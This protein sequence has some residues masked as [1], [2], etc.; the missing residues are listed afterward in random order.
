ME[1]QRRLLIFGVLTMA[2]W[3]GW[4]AIGPKFFPNLFPKP[5]EQNVAG[6][7]D[8]TDTPKPVS[9]DTPELKAAEKVADQPVPGHGGD[10]PVLALPEF[11]TQ[12]LTLGSM[13][14]QSAYGLSV[15]LTSVGAAIRSATLNDPRYPV[16]EN[17]QKLKPVPQLRLLGN[18]FSST[19]QIQPLDPERPD[20]T[21]D[22]DFAPV[23]SV[24]RQIN[25]TASLRTI[26][27]ELTG[28]ATD[29]DG[30]VSGCTF[31]IKSPDGKFELR[32]KFQLNRIPAERLQEK[33]VR[34][35]EP[36]AYQLD[37]ALQIRNTSSSEQVAEYVLQ[38]PAGLPLEYPETTR[39]YRDIKA[40]F[41]TDRGG[42][43]P[44]TMTAIEIVKA[45]DAQDIEEWTRPL[46]Y[47]GVD[48]Q[49][50]AAFVQPVENQLQTP[51]FRATR[52]VLMTR[53]EP[54]QESDISVEL[55]SSELTIPSDGGV[56]HR[57]KLFIGPKRMELL[58]PYQADK[59]LEYGWFA[60][61]SPAMVWLVSMFHDW[62]APYWIAIIMLTVIV[63]AGM[64]PISKR[65]AASG[66]KMKDLQ[67]QIMELREKYK[68]D[69][70]KLGQAQME[71]YSKAGVNPLAGCLPALIQ[72][73]IFISLYQALSNW[74]DLRMAPFLW[75]GDLSAPDALFR[76]PFRIPYLGWDFNLL[77][78]VTLVLF[79]MQQKLV[80][81]P[82]MNEEMAM[83]QKMM[84]YMT[85]FFGFLFYH[86]P[87]GLCVYFIASSCWSITE[88]QILE[89]LPEPKVDPAVVNKPR[90]EGFLAR[91]FKQ[92]QEAA[93]LQQQ[94]QKQRDEDEKHRR[95]R[96]S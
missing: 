69:K 43:A 74:V 88:R 51:Q 17:P 18:H 91:L 60:F 66:K 96:D 81:P 1:H 76:F 15:E 26:N 41:L 95:R 25:R 8:Q 64:F 14:P 62:G 90:K 13:D 35:I 40:G 92:L 7:P 31:A 46:L 93:E 78:I 38:G 39:K 32:K 71:L 28:K 83:Q 86:V 16:A 33:A 57:L 27:W 56:E 42:L 50:F 3:F 36:L 20:L 75:I 21:Y 77:P 4:L 2:T 29:A 49:Y 68:D 54:R 12:T 37:V 24:L 79:F 23:D 19:E 94:L 70:Q 58:E 6:N 52:P 59:L 61:L 22:I 63:R 11:S 87:A 5:P 85:L 45:H 82:P 9:P 67:P 89:R 73:P 47:I 80:M 48:T 44:L 30:T 10:Q 84:N 55:T 53:R 34:D 72:L 65:M